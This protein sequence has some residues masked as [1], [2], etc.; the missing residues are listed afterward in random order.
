MSYVLTRYMPSR[1]LTCSHVSS[2]VLTCPHL[3]SHVP[4]CSL[5]TSMEAS[6]FGLSEARDTQGSPWTLAALCLVHPQPKQRAPGGTRKRGPCPCVRSQCPPAQRSGDQ[7]GG[8]GA[9]GSPPLALC[10]DPRAVRRPLGNVHALPD[11]SRQLCTV[12]HVHSVCRGGR[13]P[14]ILAQMFREENLSFPSKF[15][16]STF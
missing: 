3:S 7:G 10:C 15:Y 4:T 12:P 2:R 13:A 11:T 5:V 8:D 14:T 16:F 1:L 9:D 6:R